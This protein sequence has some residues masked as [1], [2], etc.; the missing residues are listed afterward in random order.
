MCAP[1]LSRCPVSRHVFPQEDL[2]RS[3][4]SADRRE[5]ARGR[6]GAPAG[7]R[8]AREDRGSAGKRAVGAAFALG[9]ALRRQSNRARR[10]RPRRGDGDL[11][12][13]HRSGA[14]LR[15]GVGGDG[16]PGRDR[17]PGEGAQARLLAGARGVPDRAASPVLR[18][19]GPRRRPLARGL[20]HRR[21][22]RARAASS[23]SRDGVAWRGTPRSPAGRRDAVCATLREGRSGGGV[24]RLPARSTHYARH[25]VHGH[26][27]PPDQVRGVRAV[28]RSGGAAFPR[29]IGPISIR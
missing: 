24:V 15:A 10:A 7:D 21:R 3:R 16:L 1:T 14:R 20:L 12:P 11:D 22:R 4:L 23:L 19:L 26:H 25:R 9:G 28:R 29:T 17:A 27:E 18:R 2:R 5:P 13:A 8:D 6:R